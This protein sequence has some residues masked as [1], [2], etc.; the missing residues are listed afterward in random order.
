MMWF[1]L[2]WS[3]G[4]VTYQNALFV[5]DAIESDLCDYGWKIA[6]D[7]PDTAVRFVRGNKMRGV[8]GLFDE[9][10]AACQFPWYFGEN[11][12]ALAECLGDLDW[13]NSSHFVLIITRFPEVLADE[14]VEVP[15][16]GRALGDAIM[17]IIE[18]EVIPQAMIV[19]FA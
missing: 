13:I 4:I 17:G 1:E 2:Q 12:P 14:Q 15:A 3:E 8:D 18:K 9:I 11:W 6:S 5:L 7:N 19:C 10:A 16:F